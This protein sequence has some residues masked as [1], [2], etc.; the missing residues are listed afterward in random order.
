MSSFYPRGQLPEH[1]QEATSLSS[2]SKITTQ[3]DAT[4]ARIEALAITPHTGLLKAQFE[5][6]AR[7]LQA[8]NDNR[9][10]PIELAA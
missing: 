5:A 7:W 1:T 3:V 10:A 9:A 8:A 6:I 2:N 4:L